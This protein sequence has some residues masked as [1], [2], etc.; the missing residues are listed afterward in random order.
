MILSLPE[1]ARLL[2]QTE[3]QV[4]YLIKTGKLLAK[5]DGGRWVIERE[6]LELSPGQERALSRRAQAL[7]TEVDRALKPF[8]ER[9]KKPSY[10]VRDLAALTTCRALLVTARSLLDHQH[11]VLRSLE[12]AIVEL[13]RGCYRYHVPDKRAA[14]QAAREQVCEA[15][16]GLLIASDRAPENAAALD[17]LAQ[18]VEAEL[19]PAL[20]GLLRRIERERTAPRTASPGQETP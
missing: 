8:L 13:C 3:R 11:L 15:L 2:G 14:Y 4:R 16:A 6:A 5:K 19:L 20:A 17:A 1:V 9:G 7:S 18:Q 12:L 10:S